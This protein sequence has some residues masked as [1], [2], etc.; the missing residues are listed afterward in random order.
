MGPIA[1]RHRY[2]QRLRK[3]VK[4]K[5][6][7]KTVKPPKREKAPAPVEDLMAA[8]EQTLEEIKRGD[9]SPTAA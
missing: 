2:E 1:L 5:E 4:D 9:R 6:K 8:L 3:I 7:G